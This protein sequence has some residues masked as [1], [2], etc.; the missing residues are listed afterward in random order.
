MS[1]ARGFKIITMVRPQ[2]LTVVMWGREIHLKIG[3]II[4]NSKTRK[5]LS[6]AACIPIQSLKKWCVCLKRNNDY[7]LIEASMHL[8]DSTSS[9]LLLSF[10]RSYRAHSTLWM[11][12]ARTTKSNIRS[13]ALSTT[14]NHCCIMR[15]RS[16]CYRQRMTWRKWIVISRALR[17]KRTCASIQIPFPHRCLWCHNHLKDS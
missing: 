5:I 8:L 7:S 6:R 11:D 4:T 17:W 12:R 16:Q 1:R 13:H 3:M 9:L 10:L 2:E 15:K 14:R